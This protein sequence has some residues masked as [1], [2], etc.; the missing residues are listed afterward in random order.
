VGRR[1]QG[2][3]PLPTPEMPP[4]RTEY[5]RWGR[6]LR[7]EEGPQEEMPA[8]PQNRIVTLIGRGVRRH[9]ERRNERAEQA[10]RGSADAATYMERLNGELAGNGFRSAWA[11]RTKPNQAE[12]QDA[13]Y[14]GNA[15][16]RAA[17]AVF[18]GM[19]GYEGGRAASQAA[20]QAFHERFRDEPADLEAY[21]ESMAEAVGEA[22]ETGGTTGV[23]AIVERQGDRQMV[24]WGS[25][26]DSLVFLIRGQNVR[27]LNNE[28]TLRQVRLDEGA[29]EEEAEADR[30]GTILTNVLQG[31]RFDGLHQRG[32][33]ELR[34]GDVLLLVSD[35][36]TGDNSK[37]RMTGGNRIAIRQ[38]VN[39]NTMTL[40]EKVSLLIE[41]ATKIDDRSAL[42]VEI[43]DGA[44][45]D[46][47]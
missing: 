28:E 18:D 35:G 27:Q 11:E 42:L 17:F 26:G 40:V 29:T 43:A 16:N 38:I 5:Q 24:E 33:I 47:N 30:G 21:F 34:P 10:E 44:E 20:R 6:I 32:Q 46:R 23:V 14:A 4:V 15:N 13:V 19:G 2:E 36:V 7:G 9:V 37:Q 45:A 41:Y 39:S 25:V 12:S 3:D 8:G 1:R 22:T 31:G